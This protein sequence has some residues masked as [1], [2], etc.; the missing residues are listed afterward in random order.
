MGA[1]SIPWVVTNPVYVNL[2]AAHEP[3]PSERLDAER[4]TFVATH[5]WAAEASAGSESALSQGTLEDGT[6]V[7]RWT[8]RVA[9][10]PSS[11]PYA[12][13][14]FP[15]AGQLAT[16]RGIQLRARSDR[17]MRIWAQLRAPGGAGGR[18]WAQSLYVDS[19][20][21]LATLP[22]DRF[23]PVAESGAGSSPPLDEIDA[24]LVVADTV[25]SEAGTAATIAIS[26]L[27]LVR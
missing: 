19:H 6:P 3:R 15:V 7:L 21:R 8:L 1:P 13:V 27:W 16:H 12:A 4:R 20:M 24:L 2:T 18:R 26:E 22:F 10:P 5:E 11:S 14:R 17:P 9:P 23:R 25:H